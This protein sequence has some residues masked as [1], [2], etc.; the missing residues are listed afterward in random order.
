M[1][2]DATAVSRFAIPLKLLLSGL[3]RQAEG[4]FTCPGFMD[5]EW[6]IYGGFMKDLWRISGIYGGFMEDYGGSMQDLWMI[7][8]GFMEDLWVIYG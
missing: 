2:T 8:G 4:Q 7:Y 6:K 3:E 5:D 1:C